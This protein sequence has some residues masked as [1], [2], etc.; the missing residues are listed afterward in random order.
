MGLSFN[1]FVTLIMIE[2]N[3]DTQLSIGLDTEQEKLER[4]IGFVILV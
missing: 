2:K 3:K 4:T 1:A